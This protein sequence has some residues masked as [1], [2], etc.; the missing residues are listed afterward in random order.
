MKDFIKWLGVNEKIAKLVVWLLIFMIT[1]IIINACLESIGL[2]YYK[3]TIE[4]LSKIKL[5]SLVSYLCTII[6]T[7]LNYCTTIFLVIRVKNYKKV[8]LYAIPYLLILAI[9]SNINYI[10]SQIFA[11]GYCIYTIY[12]TTNQRKDIL[13][14]IASI[15]INMLVQYLT[16]YLYKFR[17]IGTNSF[18]Q[19]DRLLTSF[20]YFIIM[21]FII[22]T[23]EIYIMNKEKRGVKNV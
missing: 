11:F 17:F 21:L 10:A 4:N 15:L 2:P 18:N 14:A 9:L 19:L 3:V 5:N 1:M 20:D 6:V 8:L 22:T 16:Y 12:K 7:F 23:K 13:F